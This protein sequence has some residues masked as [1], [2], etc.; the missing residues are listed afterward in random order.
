M[1]ITPPPEN[2]PPYSEE[3]QEGHIILMKGP[4]VIGGREDVDS[5][6]ADVCDRS[7]G[8]A[9]MWNTT[10]AT[11]A[12]ISIGSRAGTEP[13]ANVDNNFSVTEGSTE[14]GEIQYV[15]ESLVENTRSDTNETNGSITTAFKDPAAPFRTDSDLLR[16]ERVSVEENR[17]ILHQAAPTPPA[18]IQF[19]RPLIRSLSVDNSDLPLEGQLRVPNPRPQSMS[20]PAPL[21]TPFPPKTTLPPLTR[22]PSNISPLLRENWVPKETLTK[23]PSR[24]PPLHRKRNRVSTWHG[25]NN[26][27]VPSEST[28]N[29]VHE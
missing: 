6:H 27:I 9:D 25:E 24:L 17:D 19:Y 1:A 2:P 7:T 5:N 12:D 20:I 16:P 14:A 21:S 23:R 11:T 28:I 8:N 3:L 4:K 15:G 13:T 26:F 22:T 10:V 18:S 29:T